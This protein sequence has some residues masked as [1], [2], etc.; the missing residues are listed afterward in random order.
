MGFLLV[1]S[2]AGPKGVSVYRALPV[3]GVKR[4]STEFVIIGRLVSGHLANIVSTVG[5]IDLRLC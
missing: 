3:V 5:N 4:F 2:T 1:G